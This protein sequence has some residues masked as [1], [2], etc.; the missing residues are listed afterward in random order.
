MML[1]VTKCYFVTS[2]IFSNGIAFAVWCNAM[3]PARIIIHLP[4]SSVKQMLAAVCHVM[5]IHR[6]C[7]VG[8]S[9]E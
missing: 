4:S 9:D 8:C 5:S 1:D 6:H 3:L 2:G 7:L